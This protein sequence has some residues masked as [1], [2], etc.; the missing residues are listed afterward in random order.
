[1]SNPEPELS[2]LSEAELA[3]LISAAV[4]ELIRALPCATE[5]EDE[6]KTRLISLLADAGCRAPESIASHIDM[7]CG[8]PLGLDWPASDLAKTLAVVLDLPALTARVEDEG[9]P[10][11]ARRFA[12]RCLL[13]LQDP[14]AHRLAL[15]RAP[16]LE[17]E[18]NLFSREVGELFEET[19]L[20]ADD[21]ELRRLYPGPCHHLV[22]EP[23]YLDR[24]AEKIDPHPSWSLP[25]GGPALRLG[26]RAEGQCGDCG[27]PLMNMLSL[28]GDLTPF[29]VSLP[30]LELSLCLSCFAHDGWAGQ[31]V[32]YSREGLA[33]RPACAPWSPGP[34]ERAP[35]LVQTRV[36]L[37]PTPPP[38]S[39]PCLGLHEGNHNQLGGSPAWIHEPELP[40]C[41]DCDRRMLFL[42][43]LDGDLI[44]DGGDDAKNWWGAS[45]MA[46]FFW[47]DRCRV[48]QL[49]AQH[50]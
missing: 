37:A 43:Q 12:W 47:C 39:R 6:A 50:L 27:Q 8:L 42:L 3:E 26:G 9:L 19:G 20:D 36:R 35:P 23:A 41:P 5:E 2:S 33:E 13:E 21:P 34:E 32:R 31:T 25:G 10:L 11:A 40:R 17:V 1:M 18:D 15:A 14:A 24:M 7:L 49:V 38:W 44:P 46:Y 48:V 28:Q 16:A 45:G 29:G 4:A 22:F 30:R